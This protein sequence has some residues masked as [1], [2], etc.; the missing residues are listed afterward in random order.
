MKK[1]KILFLG[2]AAFQLPPIQYAL[3]QGYRVITADNNPDNPCHQFAETAYSVS[4]TDRE[5]ILQIAQKEEIDGIMTFASDVSMPTVAYV[6]EKLNLPAPNYE[7]TLVLTNK[8]L[9]RQFLQNEGLQTQFFQNFEAYEKQVA[10]AYIRLAKLPII[11]KPVDRSGSRGVGIVQILEE[12]EKRVEEA[13]EVS[14]KKEIIVEQYIEKQGRQI[15]GD[16]YMEDGKLAFVAFGDGHFYTDERFMAPYAETFPSEHSPSLLKMTAQ[17]LE[18]ILQRVGYDQGPFNLDV[19]I[20]KAGEIFV[21]EIGPRCGGNYIPILIQLRYGVD[22]VAAAVEGCLTANYKL[23]IP[24][25]FSPKY[26][27]ASYMIHSLQSGDLK[28]IQLDNSLKDKIHAHHPYIG[29]TDKISAFHQAGAAI[30]N[31][32]FRFD[33]EREMHQMMDT[34]NDLVKVMVE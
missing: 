28:G 31:L 32:I 29:K 23:S 4:T 13:F 8:A 30:G 27:Y 25:F 6:A 16:G 17:K 5:S 3:N 15:C 11:I 9:F 10:L 18:Q 24:K 19:L 2:A 1:K 26:H 33:S 20:T 34:I 22:L 12:A 21:N 7:T 14:I